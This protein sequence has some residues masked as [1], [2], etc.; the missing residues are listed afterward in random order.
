MQRMFERMIRPVFHQ[1]I[2]TKG[3]K[4]ISGEKAVNNTLNSYLRVQGTGVPLH[5]EGKDG[6]R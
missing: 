3:M 4:I 1:R 6:G 5:P 2:T